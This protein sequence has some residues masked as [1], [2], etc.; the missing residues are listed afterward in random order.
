MQ[1]AESGAA[2]ILM[3]SRGT[4]QTMTQPELCTYTDVYHDVAHELQAAAD[5]AVAAGIP[6]WQI[7]LDPGVGF[8]KGAADNARLVT[9]WPRLRPHLQGACPVLLRHHAMLHALMP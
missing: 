3:H 5:A 8:A 4:P 1:V 2:C 7:M 9:A 6:A